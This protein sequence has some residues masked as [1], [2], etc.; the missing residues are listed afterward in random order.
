MQ[1][2][3]LGNSCNVKYQINKYYIKNKILNNPTLFFDWLLT[4]FTSVLEIF[5][6]HNRINELFKI[7]NIEITG[8]LNNNTRVKFKNLLL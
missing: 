8:I 4:S 7:E 5:K 2:V 6:Y 1:L 3:S